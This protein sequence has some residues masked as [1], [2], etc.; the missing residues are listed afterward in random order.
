MYVCRETPRSFIGLWH[1]PPRPL[2]YHGIC[3][4]GTA[5]AVCL[6]YS[7]IGWGVVI[8]AGL[9]PGAPQANCGQFS[10]SNL[11]QLFM[12]L[13]TSFMAPIALLTTTREGSPILWSFLRFLPSY[14]RELFFFPITWPVRHFETLT[15][16]NG[17]TNKM[18]LTWLKKASLNK[19]FNPYS[20]MN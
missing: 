3:R 2:T 15:Q 8:P 6:R 10:I 17:Q 16:I 13:C 7:G 4:S 20:L 9:N 5:Y 19:M 14:L 18:E 1:V 12:L 11:L